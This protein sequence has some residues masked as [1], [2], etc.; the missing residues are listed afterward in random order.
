LSYCRQRFRF[1]LFCEQDVVLVFFNKFAAALNK[2]AAALN[3]FAAALS[4]WYTQRLEPLWFRR[5]RPKRLQS[6]SPALELPQLPVAQLQLEGSQG[7]DSPL[8]RR[9]QR[10]YQ[11]VLPVVALQRGLL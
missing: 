9:Y 3:K 8:I 6:F 10:Y 5:R 11:Q 1:R 2:F 7:G 4:K